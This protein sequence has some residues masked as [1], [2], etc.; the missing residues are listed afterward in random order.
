MFNRGHETSNWFTMANALKRILLFLMSVGLLCVQSPIGIDF[1]SACGSLFLA[2]TANCAFL[3]LPCTL[4]SCV[5]APAGDLTLCSGFGRW[6]RT[7]FECAWTATGLR[8]TFGGNPG[9]QVRHAG[10]SLGSLCTRTMVLFTMGFSQRFQLTSTNIPKH[11]A[12]RIITR[13]IHAL[14]AFSQKQHLETYRLCGPGNGRTNGCK[15]A[16]RAI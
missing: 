14:G 15:I 2:C 7:T 5:D 12:Y 8:T 16:Q 9:H 1:R 10:R 11:W 4:D 13:T 3:S 6:Q